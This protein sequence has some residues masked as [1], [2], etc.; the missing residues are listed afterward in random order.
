M[1]RLNVI[2]KTTGEYPTIEVLEDIARKG[3]LLVYD[4]NQFYL[5]KMVVFFF[6]M[7]AIKW[8]LL[9]QNDLS[10]Y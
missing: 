3:G 1:F 9:T 6:L 7:I 8:W 10:L 5:M 2:D 4:I